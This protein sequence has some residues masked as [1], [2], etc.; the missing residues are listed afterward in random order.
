VAISTPHI[1]LHQL[2]DVS[3]ERDCA[4]VAERK[5]LGP[6]VAV[7]EVEVL[8]PFVIILHSAIDARPEHG[9]HLS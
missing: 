8:A 6:R 9:L 3:S 7:V 1:A 5:L 4:W 2:G